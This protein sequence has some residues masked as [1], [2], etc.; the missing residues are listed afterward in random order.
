MKKLILIVCFAFS[1]TN[2]FSQKVG[3]VS[4][5]VIRE[6]FPE[7]QQANQR[8]QSI[9]EEWKRELNNLEKQIEALEFEIQKNRLIW[10]DEE[11]LQKEKEKND[12]IAQRREYARSKF[13]SGGEY[14]QTVKTIMQPVEEKIYA[15]IQEV[16]TEENYD[17]IWDKS[18]N[19][20][21]YVNFKYD[22]TV[23]VLKKLGV[24]VKKLEEELQEKIAKDPR[25]QKPETKAPPRGRARE[26]TKQEIEKQDKQERE[27]E[28][29]KDE[30]KEELKKEFERR[31]K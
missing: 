27:E 12:L 22:L 29:P 14:E 26:R 17:I 6:K 5:D 8:I 28:Q 24:D 23:K 7:A 9:V 18:V 21:V 10:S 11:R 20:L 19:P 25:N 30:P 13:E 31:K 4:T 15:A 2:L 16:C 1:F 3:F